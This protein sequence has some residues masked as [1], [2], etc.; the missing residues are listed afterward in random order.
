MP[1]RSGFRQPSQQDSGVKTR[2][3]KKT[4][5]ESFPE[6]ATYR[7]HRL[8]TLS[9]RLIGTRYRQQFGLRMMEVGILI[10]VGGSG[11][12][13]FKSTY[14]YA[15]LEKSNASRLTAQLLEKGLLEK[16]VD[17]A[18]QRSFYLALTPAGEK[19]YRELYAD[20][21]ARNR[22]WISVLPRKQQAI[23]LRS[24]ERLTEHTQKLLEELGGNAFSDRVGG[25]RELEPPQR[26]IL[27]NAAA[28]QLYALLGTALGKE[29]SR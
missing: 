26:I 2:K 7:L 9:E 1:A 25:T 24:L 29:R 3:K 23:F 20:A 10:L 16:R 19:L 17:P 28:S 5:Q 15:S 8:A 6:L 21:C 11:P 12:L 4:R 22:K 13:S 14:T 18:D 27:D